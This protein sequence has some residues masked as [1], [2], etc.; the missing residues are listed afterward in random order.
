MR[1]LV[2]WQQHLLRHFKPE[3]ELLQIYGPPPT[4]RIERYGSPV[5]DDFCEEN[6]LPDEFSYWA[7]VEQ[8]Q[9]KSSDHMDVEQPRDDSR[10][11]MRSHP[12]AAAQRHQPACGATPL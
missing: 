8:L 9:H 12:L 6:H 3:A 1:A 4:D 2:D 10:E 5:D 7:E 11:M